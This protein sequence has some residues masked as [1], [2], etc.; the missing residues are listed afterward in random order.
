MPRSL[1]GCVPVVA[2][3]VLACG[4]SGAARPAV[5][6]VSLTASSTG[7][8]AS[9]GDTIQLTAVA[10]DANKVAIPGVAV[11][12]TSSTPAA[13]TVTQAGLVTA[14]ANGTTTIHAAADAKEATLDVVVSQV[15]TSVLV[16][17][18]SIRVPPNETPLFRAAA[19][20]ARGNVVAGAAA[21]AWTTSNSAIA[22]IVASG[23]A[24][25]SSSA[26]NGWTVSAI[27]TIGSLTSSAG[28]Q[29]I[30]DSTATYVESIAVAASGGSTSLTSLNQ[31]VQ[32]S[33]TASNSKGVVTSPVSF[34]WST[35]AA[36]V[37][38]VSASGLV[39]AIGNGTATI[40]ATSNGVSGT[41][42]V[43]V[44]QVVAKVNVATASGTPAPTLASLGDTLQLAATALDAG[45]SA[46]AGASFAWSSDTALVAT[47][48]GDGLVTAKGN[49]TAHVF[50]KA[51][52]NQ[53]ANPAP[54][55]AVSVQ[56]TVATVSV[57]PSS[58]TIP[59]CTTTQYAAIAKDARGNPVGS[60]QTW[61]SSNTAIATVDGTGLAR[62]MAVG[63]PVEIRAT[64]G[65]VLGKALLTVD[66]SPIR[67]NWSTA[68]TTLNVT[69]CAGQSII[70]HNSDTNVVHT[71]TGTNA[72]PN[73][74]DIQPGTD[75]TPQ[76]F[77]TA[78]S[79]TY[80][81]LYHP[82]SGT[83]TVQ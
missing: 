72:L 25:V 70:W 31:T 40:S 26:V 15:A 73:T 11:T 21:P 29:M 49:G 75:S 66:S 47:V 82:H 55:F 39:T 76:T 65:G 58:A 74:A 48:G 57:T 80:R 41:L 81:C 62:G 45:G 16:T 24:T 43:N 1:V 34:T 4:G 37:A 20:D 28:G 13:A 42:A 33:A 54:G 44:A 18:L 32:L 9:L 7:P 56:Q 69:I 77:P 23:R 68:Q 17:P 6:S 22:T 30:I 67:V 46:V 19:L 27:A 36:A 8:L 53:V 52:S 50:A 3:L 64:I 38:T 12:F 35:N 71:A 63:G 14:I 59:R 60:P 78:G 51:T 2:M 10:L 61:S 5:A 83:V 79:Y